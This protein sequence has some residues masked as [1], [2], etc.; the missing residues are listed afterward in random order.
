MTTFLLAAILV[1]WVGLIQGPPRPLTSYNV[2][3]WYGCLTVTMLSSLYQD[4][5][6]RDGYLEAVGEG[7][8][9]HHPAMWLIGWALLFLTMNK[10]K[11]RLQP[12][13]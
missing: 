3:F 6:G 1:L 13:E 9:D 12:P 2:G 7:W 11:A 5:L 4:Y 8:Q 10:F